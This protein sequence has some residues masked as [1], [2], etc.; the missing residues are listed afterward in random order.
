[1]MKK[2][3]NFLKLFKINYIMQS[4]VIYERADS[5]KPFI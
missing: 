2:Q 1:M 5:E 4:E 3:L